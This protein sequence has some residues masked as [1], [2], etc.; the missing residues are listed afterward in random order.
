MYSHQSVRDTCKSTQVR[1]A[2]GKAGTDL[3]FTVLRKIPR[4]LKALPVRLPNEMLESIFG[5]W[6]SISTLPRIWNIHSKST[7][8]SVP[9]YTKQAAQNRLVILRILTEM[10]DGN[11]EVGRNI[12]SAATTVQ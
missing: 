5:C 8:S 6:P 10:P 3:D 11:H 1:R 7:S 12:Y 9:S 2:P 4:I